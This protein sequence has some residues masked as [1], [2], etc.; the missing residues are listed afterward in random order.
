MHHMSDAD[1][2][3]WAFLPAALIAER[4]FGYQLDDAGPHTPLSGSAGL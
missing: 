3:G 1:R 4:S 2:L